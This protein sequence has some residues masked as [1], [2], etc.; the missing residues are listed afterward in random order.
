LILVERDIYSE[1]K[2]S[3]D[4]CREFVS[5]IVNAYYWRTSN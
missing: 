2:I 4:R 3:N 5:F 1:N